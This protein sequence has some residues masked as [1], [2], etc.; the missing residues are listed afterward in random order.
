MLSHEEAQEL[1][2]LVGAPLE[3]ARKNG[4]FDPEEVT[5][6]AS[7]LERAR[8]LAALLV[9]DSD[10]DNEPEDKFTWSDWQSEEDELGSDG[11]V[12]VYWIEISDPNGEEYA[13]IVHRTVGVDSRRI[14]A[15]AGTVSQPGAAI[16]AG[17]RVNLGEAI[18]HG[19]ASPAAQRRALA[20]ACKR[21]AWVAPTWAMTARP[22]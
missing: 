18:T 10:P 12:G 13:V 11:R 6:K 2:L 1:H 5:V 7:D 15:D 9:S 19:G 16:V 21:A 14:L 8:E 22:T 4:A 3:L 17:A 20:W